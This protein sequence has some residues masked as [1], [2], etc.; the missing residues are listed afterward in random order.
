V[1]SVVIVPQASSSMSPPVVV[2]PAPLDP[3]SLG[4][5]SPSPLTQ[6]MS[7]DQE[8]TRM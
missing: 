5:T 8:W 4:W 3:L 2:P 1:A 7:F 6:L